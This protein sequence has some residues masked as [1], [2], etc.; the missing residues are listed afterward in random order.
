MTQLEEV[1]QTLAEVANDV[2]LAEFG[3]EFRVLRLRASA[4]IVSLVNTKTGTTV[5]DDGMTLDYLPETVCRNYAKC[6]AYELAGRFLRRQHP[7]A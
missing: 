7:L 3:M 5:L 2:H 4:Y 6:R 1:E